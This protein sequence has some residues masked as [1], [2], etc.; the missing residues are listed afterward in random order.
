MRL[1]SE[2]C[3]N[4][5]CVGALGVRLEKATRGQLSLGSTA[6]IEQRL[7]ANVRRLL[8]ELPVRNLPTVIVQQS[9]RTVGIVSG[10]RVARGIEQSDFSV[11]HC[12]RRWLSV[13]NRKRASRDG[14]LRA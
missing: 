1:R 6:A 3:S 4:A 14:P 9:Q 11:E 2:Q 13:L 5:L 7:D 12:G 10:D 8:R